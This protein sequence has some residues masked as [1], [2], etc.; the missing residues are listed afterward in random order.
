MTHVLASALFDYAADRYGATRIGPDGDFDINKP[1]VLDRVEP[2][3]LSFCTGATIPD[4]ALGVAGAVLLC[5]PDAAAAVQRTSTTT[6]MVVENPR[7]V[8]G[9]LVSAFLA[10]KAETGIHPSASIHEQAQIGA[11]VSIG[12]GVVVGP[13]CSIGDGSVIGANVVLERNVQVGQGCTI[14]AGSTLG[15]PGFGIEQDIDGSMFQLPHVGGVILE[16]GVTIGSQCTVV[17]GTILPT[18]VCQNVMTDDHV[19]IAHNVTVGP[20]S[21]LT[22]CAEISGSVTIGA[23]VWLGPNCSIMNKVKIGDRSMVGLGAVVTKP[24]DE[25]TVIAGN[26]ARALK[27]RF[28]E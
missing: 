8:F 7:L 5:K 17:A 4:A 28:P 11:N 24:F 23:D 10:P 21:L 25:N 22:A 19:H 15:H 14:R 1:T 3:C 18:R 26:P 6:L 27:K 2:A 9:R 20:R 12:P 16:D 13:D